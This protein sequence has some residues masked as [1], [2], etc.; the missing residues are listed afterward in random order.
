MKIRL[1]AIILCIVGQLFGQNQPA[2]EAELTIKFTVGRRVKYS[3][4]RDYVLHSESLHARQCLSKYRWAKFGAHR[5]AIQEWYGQKLRGGKWGGHVCTVLDT[6]QIGFYKDEDGGDYH[7]SQ[8]NDP[9]DI[10]LECVFKVA[11]SNILRFRNLVIDSLGNKKSAHYQYR[12]FPSSERCTS[13]TLRL[14]SL[15]GVPIDGINRRFRWHGM[16]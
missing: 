5:Y 14:W 10:Y 12:F 11:D 16:S 1:L 7:L 8:V 4:S 13:N 2:E 6:F 9:R 3:Y 15:S